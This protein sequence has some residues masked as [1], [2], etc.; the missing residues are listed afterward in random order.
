M[1]NKGIATE[2]ILL[3]LVAVIVL[4]VIVLLIY[5]TTTDSNLTSTACMGKVVDWCTRCKLKG[6]SAWKKQD[7]DNNDLAK[8]SCLSTGTN[9]D[10]WVSKC[11][12]DP[13]LGEFA[14]WNFDPVAIAVYEDDVVQYCPR[15]GVE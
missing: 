9:W 12:D 15:V 2:T 8:C 4:V 6:P 13:S 3:I 1:I 14:H 7:C 11:V 10:L 5:T